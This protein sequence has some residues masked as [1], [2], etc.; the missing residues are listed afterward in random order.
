MMGHIK[1]GCATRRIGRASQRASKRAPCSVPAVPAVPAVSAVSKEGQNEGQ[2]EITLLD[3][4]AGN[5]RS[6]KNAI[7]KLGYT[8][9]EVESIRD[10]ERAERLVFPGVGAF[11]QAMQALRSKGYDE[12]LR[13]YLAEAEAGR[14]SFFGICIGMQVLFEE[15]AEDGGCEGLGVVPGVVGRFE[16]SAG[17]Q[18][19]HIGW[20][21]I[22]QRRPSGLLG[23]V[24]GGDRMYFVHSYRAVPD[25]RNHDYVLATCDYGGEFVAAVNKG[26]VYATQVRW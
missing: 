22:D 3:Y 11:G 14:G 19:P 13:A 25:A 18:I 12:A 17:I 20:N 16:E 24:G 9:K 4:G 23:D 15:S 6:I 1:M 10:I 5:I 7:T 8:I 2:K 26:N 21:N